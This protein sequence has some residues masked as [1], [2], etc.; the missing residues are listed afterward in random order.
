MPEEILQISANHYFKPLYLVGFSSTAAFTSPRTCL[1]K[2][3]RQ[4]LVSSVKRQL[5]NILADSGLSRHLK[6]SCKTF[7]VHVQLV[8]IVSRFFLSSHRRSD[9]SMHNH[10]TK[11]M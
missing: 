3:N 9:L 4:I 2:M 10:T 7:D 11:L 8:C 5:A 6:L 1:F